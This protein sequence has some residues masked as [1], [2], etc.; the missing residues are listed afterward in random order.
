MRV[1]TERAAPTGKPAD[2]ALGTE[3]VACE[4]AGVKALVGGLDRVYA[5]LERPRMS[6]T[7]A[8]AQRGWYW[9]EICMGGC[10]HYRPDC[11]E[12][13]RLADCMK[14]MD[15]RLRRE[16]DEAVPMF[17]SRRERDEYWVDLHHASGENMHFGKEE[18]DG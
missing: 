10:D 11:L 8:E 9:N 18:H 6:D 5:A 12:S 3:I 15:A 2:A 14:N 1:D 16:M 13:D 7:R 17:R 4:E